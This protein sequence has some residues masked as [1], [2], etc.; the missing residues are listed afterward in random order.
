MSTSLEKRIRKLHPFAFDDRCPACKGSGYV[1]CPFCFG[2]DLDIQPCY[3]CSSKG[4]IPCSTC[5][6]EGVIE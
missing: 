1:V 6:G 2:E 4:Q 5:D 3:E